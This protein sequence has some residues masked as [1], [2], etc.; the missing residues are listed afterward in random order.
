VRKQIGNGLQFDFNYTYSKSIDITST[1]SRVSFA[2]VGYQNIGLVGSRLENA[3]NPNSQRAVSDFDLTHQVNANW[4]AQLLFGRG[5][6]FASHG[7]S[8]SDGLVGGWELRGVGRWT[9]GFP[10]A[11]MWARTGRPT[12]STRGWHNWLGRSRIRAFIAIPMAR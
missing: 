8:V 3:F 4:L 7:S 6:R 1:A 9:S 10:S 5:R 2:R 12:G 11:W